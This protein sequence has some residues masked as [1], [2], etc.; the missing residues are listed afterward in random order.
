MTGL[1]RLIE[2]RAFLRATASLSVWVSMIPP[3]RADGEPARLLVIGDSQAQGLAGGVQRLL[4]RDRS[5]RVLDRTKIGT[6]LVSPRAYDWTAAVRTLA[7]SEH[8]D[9]ALVM[10]GANDRPP[11]HG[12]DGTVIPGLS[13]AFTQSY[14]ARVREIVQT[15][16]E[17]GIPV[18]W[19]GHPTVRDPRYADDM[20]MLNR[21]FADAATTAGADYVPIWDLFASDGKYQPYG[22]GVDGETTRL[23][24]DDG[25]HLTPA[26]YDVLAVYL[27]PHIQSDLRARTER[28]V[29]AAPVQP[30]RHETEA[31]KSTGAAVADH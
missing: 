27:L 16:R 20:A 15:L 11:V 1:R 21:I 19:V 26:G 18:I 8:A 7:A 24:A 2:R 28:T 17:A 9:V 25:V 31:V 29:R 5:I 13:L 12:G 10:F 14:G 23:R 4:R 30:V 3:V 6:G 22:K